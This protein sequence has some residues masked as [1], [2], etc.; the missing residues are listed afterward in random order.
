LKVLE[1]HY[2]NIVGTLG[3]AVVGGLEAD[4]VGNWTYAI[5]TSGIK[6]TWLLK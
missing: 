5:A 1:F 2:Q 3:R 6:T 4:A